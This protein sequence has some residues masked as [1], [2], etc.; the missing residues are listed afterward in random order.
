MGIG[1]LAGCPGALDAHEMLGGL[2]FS[3]RL[4]G[5]LACASPYRPQSTSSPFSHLMV[6]P[7][8]VSKMLSA[9]LRCSCMSPVFTYGNVSVASASLG[10]PTYKRPLVCPHTLCA[11]ME[12]PWPSL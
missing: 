3:R 2:C 1:I 12:W 4:Q 11:G 6:T 8:A 5:L 10:S 7:Q 9:D